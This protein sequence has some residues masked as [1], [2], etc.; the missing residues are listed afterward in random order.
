MILGAKNYK[1]D[2]F[3]V[4]NKIVYNDNDSISNSVNYGYKTVFANIFEY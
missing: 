3:I 4:K 1:H 2:Y